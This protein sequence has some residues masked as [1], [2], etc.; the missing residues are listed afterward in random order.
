MQAGERRATGKPLVNASPPGNLSLHSARRA[1]ASHCS[2]VAHNVRSSADCYAVS[3]QL[4]EISLSGS[5]CAFNKQIG[6]KWTDKNLEV[7]LRVDVVNGKVGA[8]I[9]GATQVW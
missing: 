1:M 8:H 3:Q 4:D 6:C 7:I 2:K 5:R 9:I